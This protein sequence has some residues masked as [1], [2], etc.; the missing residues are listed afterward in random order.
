MLTQSNPGWEGCRA[1]IQET[2]ARLPCLVHPPA[3]WRLVYDGYP[4]KVYQIAK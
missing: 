4:A 2:V 3:N 1:V